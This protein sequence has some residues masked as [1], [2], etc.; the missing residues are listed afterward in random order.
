MPLTEEQQQIIHHH[1]G[2]AKVN[3]VAGS[4]KTTTMVARIRHLLEQGVPAAGI[5]VLMF[6]RSARESFATKLAASLQ[7]SRLAPPEVRTFHSLGLRLVD[8]FCQRGA[9]PRRT[10][11][12]ADYQLEALAKA[13]I[14]KTMERH[15]NDRDWLSKESLEVFLTFIDLVKAN[16]SPAAALFAKLDL[17]P[18]FAYFVEAY[19][20]FEELRQGQGGRFFADLVHEP[21]MALLAD[22]TLAGWVG[23]RVDHIIV[24]EYQ[25]INEVQQQLLKAIAGERAQV[26]VVGDVDQCIYEWRGAQPVYIT[27]RFQ[28]DFPQPT[29]YTLS[30]TFRFGHRLSLAANHLIRHNPLPGRKLCLASPAN[31]DTRLDCL[32]E[33]SPH[34]ALA[35][36]A[37]WQG[38]QGRSLR[39]AA[40]LV[41]IFALSVPLE[42]ALIAGGIPYRL[43]G[44]E[45]VFACPEIMA[46]TGF[47]R[48]CQSR[49]PLSSETTVAAM[50][51][52]P[53]LG[54]KRERL[55]SLARAIA[56]EPAQAPK[57]ITAQIDHHT[58]AFLQR[59]LEERALAWQAIRRLSPKAKAH[60]LLSQIIKLTGL[61]AFYH[62][63]ATRL[64]QAENRIKTCQAY[65]SFAKRLNLTLIPFLAEVDR[66]QEV[67]QEPEGEALLITSVHRAKGL[68]WPLVILPGLSEGSFPFIDERS[69]SAC[70][71]QEDERR[72]F[73]VAM[74]RAKERLVCLHPEGTSLQRQQGGGPRRPQQPETSP[75]ASRFLY[76]A[77]IELCNRV[78]EAI[79]GEP[80]PS[81]ALVAHD[82][83][84]ANDY[85]T[86]IGVTGLR[87]GCPQVK[88]GG[89]GRAGGIFL[90]I[91]E[92]GEGMVV[93]HQRFGQGVVSA[94]PDRRKGKV[95]IRFAH[96]GTK[97][98]VAKIAGL[99]TP[100][101]EES[102]AKRHPL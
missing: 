43:L 93:C 2:H 7:S 18:S 5:M 89:K 76:E 49:Q 74:T 90:T 8:S 19:A 60:E 53:H 20:V 77:N 61:F 73:Y 21:V 9:L 22:P 85:L 94:V 40:A 80:P 50:L 30:T 99:T 81:E 3:A 55:A 45:R 83:Q 12:T 59:Q 71:G 31:P 97:V 1:Q 79:Y 11:I 102:P 33:G 29:T 87:V 35:I 41:R 75:A 54:L 10:L 86:A 47:L 67:S 64:S 92:L 58:P 36:L 98:L 27:E 16:T 57:L 70:Q 52:N 26:M 101:R 69:N 15:D 78:G 17:P 88:E 96:H 95:E 42:L 4:G 84:L 68:E 32:V 24:D 39:E 46:L 51:A 72:L 38:G 100:C 65:L 63:F 13:A 82:G 25:D 56:L 62:S 91:E 37:D 34:P 28:E 48:L 44:H 14:K 6:N 23:N 66:L